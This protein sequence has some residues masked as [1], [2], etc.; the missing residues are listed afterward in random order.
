M[1]ISEAR[2]HLRLRHR[3]PP[4]TI[5]FRLP[6]ASGYLYTFRHKV[7]LECI[8]SQSL[9]PHCVQVVFSPSFVACLWTV[10]TLLSRCKAFTLQIL[11]SKGFSCTCI[12][13]LL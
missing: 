10:V 8:L 6:D 11:S 7:Q 2:V 12:E 9:A 5:D 13:T 4:A 1:I 3:R